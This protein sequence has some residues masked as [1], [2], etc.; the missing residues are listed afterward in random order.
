[1]KPLTPESSAPASAQA[2]DSLPEDA[3]NQ[4]PAPRRGARA[5]RTEGDARIS[6]NVSRL[7]PWVPWSMAAYT[8]WVALFAFPDVV[9]IWL[10]VLYAG[11]L[12]K[13]GHL[14]PARRQGRMF[15]HGAL[16]I[17]AAYLLHTHISDRLEGPGGPF[18][19]WVAVPALAYAFILKPR[20][21]MGIVALAVTEF[22]VSSAMTEAGVASSIALAGF[23]ILFP[24]ALAL[25]FGE[26]MR[27]PDELLELGRRDPATGLLNRQGLAFHGDELLRDCRREK[28]PLTL[29]V[30]ACED[31]ATVRQMYG[32]KV[33]RKALG[34]LVDKLQAAAGSRGFV[35]RTGP[36]QFSLLIPAVTRDKALA[37]IGRQL[38]S[39]LRLEF[40]AGSEEIVML[41]LLVL[42]SV[43]AAESSIESLHAELCAELLDAVAAARQGVIVP[44]PEPSVAP[45]TS[46][47]PSIASS[48]RDTGEPS[49]VMNH[50]PSTI[51]AGL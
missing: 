35:A 42:E 6:P 33:G 41:P 12:G 14:F 5:A 27:K 22:A 31:L 48:L 24:L 20:W 45:P 7:E 51:P 46:I 25:P 47:A 39:P 21:A 38:G 32:R 10:F 18:F 8:A 44:E 43:R 50:L 15:A 16:L 2:T 40:D 36:A 29:A 23:L 19:F 17:C 11:V 28:K 9:A 26:A 49:T 3:E 13:W 34:L 30:V 4:E 1:M 37:L